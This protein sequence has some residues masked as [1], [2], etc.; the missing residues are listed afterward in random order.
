MNYLLFL[1]FKTKSVKLGEELSGKDVYV[2]VKGKDTNLVTGIPV[3]SEYQALLNKKIRLKTD[4]NGK[5]ALNFGTINQSQMNQTI[6]TEIDFDQLSEESTRDRMV[7]ALLKYLPTKSC[8]ST[9]TVYPPKIYIVSK[10]KELGKGVKSNLEGGIKQALISKG[11]EV[12]TY[13]DNADLILVINGNTEDAGINREAHLVFFKGNIEV[14]QRSDNRLVFSEVIREEK[15]VQL[16]LKRASDDA[17]S[18][19]GDYVK[20]RIIPKLANKYFSF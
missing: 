14:Y 20:R 11:F 6:I 16:D 2:H 18:K 4:V 1:H 17:Y 12:T 15:G 8:K 10:E 19:A 13:K 5:A 7:L 3:I 9:L